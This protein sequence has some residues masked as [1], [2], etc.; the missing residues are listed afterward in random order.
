MARDDPGHW[1]NRVKKH[2]HIIANR[3][4]EIVIGLVLFAF[5]AMLLYD[6]FDGRGKKLIWPFSAIL[7]W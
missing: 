4:A 5:G 3:H 2:G 7:P 1:K 6:A